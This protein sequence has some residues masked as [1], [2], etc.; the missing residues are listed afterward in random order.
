LC[1]LTGA[2]FNLNSNS[3]KY[4]GW[5]DLNPRPVAA[6]TVLPIQSIQLISGEM[7]VAYFLVSAGRG[8]FL[9]PMVA[10]RR[11]F[12]VSH[13]STFSF[14]ALVCRASIPF[15]R[16]TRPNQSVKPTAISSGRDTFGFD[17]ILRGQPHGVIEL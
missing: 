12:I 2:R 11:C 17:R 15:V 13:F 16:G 1:R 8:F 6:A 4:S 9:S 3:R 10:R 7:A 14:G 5:R